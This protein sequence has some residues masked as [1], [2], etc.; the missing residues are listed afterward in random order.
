MKIDAG[1]LLQVQAQGLGRPFAANR[2]WMLY[3]GLVIALVTWLLCWYG[4][5]FVSIV[6]IWRRSDTYAHGFLILPI[7][8]WLIWRNRDRVAAL[9]QHAEYIP[10]AVLALLGLGWLLADVA[11]VLPAAQY[12][13]VAMM[14]VLA[15]A[16]LGRRV[17]AE[18]AFPLGYLLFA[19]PIGEFMLPTLISQTADF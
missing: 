11:G 2:G 1:T 12:C 5:T 13:V 19:V 15:W 16:V 8:G 6:D 3:A 9:T 17:A 18:L 14:P 4:D 7:S 10:L